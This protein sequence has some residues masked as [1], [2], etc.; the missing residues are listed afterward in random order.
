MRD[1][2]KAE[3]MAAQRVQLLSPLLAEGL[4]GAQAKLIKARI[5]E[6]TGISERTLRR[7]LSQYRNDGFGGLKP[8]GKGR[9]QSEEAIPV[10]ILE[11]AVLLRRQVPGRSITQIIQILE[12]E[13]LAEPGQI[14]RSTLQEKLAE[15]GYSARHMRLYADTSVAARRYQKRYRNQLWHSDIKYGP[16]IV[17][18]LGNM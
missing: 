9:R 17:P 11:Q 10:N 5:C 1:Q 12:W 13:G 6:Q 7:Y 15:R 2:R 14:K 4:D 16:W 8:K 18:R 3:E